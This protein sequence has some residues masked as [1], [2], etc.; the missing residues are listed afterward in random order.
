MIIV[1]GE[2]IEAQSARYDA[3]LASVDY[4]PS[5]LREMSRDDAEFCVVFLHSRLIDLTRAM[6]A[7]ATEAECEAEIAYCLSCGETT[8]D[9]LVTLAV[10]KLEADLPQTLRD[11]A[12]VW[13]SNCAIK[14]QIAFAM[15]RN[16]S[17][18]N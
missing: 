17:T 8:L 2:T 6:N 13:V 12:A 5:R 9:R 11:M 7:K 16:V 1:L 14:N 4:N 18:V 15:E 10:K 3:A